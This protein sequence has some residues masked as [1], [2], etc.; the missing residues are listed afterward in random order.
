M[1]TR[2]PQSNQTNQFHFAMPSRKK[3]KGK[4]RKAKAAAAEAV[5]AQQEQ[6][7]H[8]LLSIRKGSVEE[9]QCRTSMIHCTMQSILLKRSP[10][11]D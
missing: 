8:Q 10:G 1:N 3:R 9:F 2:L 5:V 4:A 7:V 6:A 11:T